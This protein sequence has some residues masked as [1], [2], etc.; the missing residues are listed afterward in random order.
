LEVLFASLLGVIFLNENISSPLIIGSIMVI[1]GGTPV[2]FFDNSGA[3][4]ENVPK[5]VLMQ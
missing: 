5:K 2:I 3:E 1:G 4:R